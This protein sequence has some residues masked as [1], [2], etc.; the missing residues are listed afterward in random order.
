[1]LD[2]VS[3]MNQLQALFLH[4][5]ELGK[6]SHAYLFLGSDQ[7]A[8]QT[9]VALIAGKILREDPQNDVF[10]N[11]NLVKIDLLPEK[12]TLSVEQ[13]RSLRDIFAERSDDPQI[14]VIM[15]ADQMTDSAANSILK[16]IEEPYDNQFIFLLGT[17]FS[18][19][20]PTIL[21]RVQL[22]KIP[23]ASDHEISQQLINQGIQADE[24]IFVSKISRSIK[25]AKDLLTDGFAINLKR[26]I[27]QWL[28]AILLNDEKAF[29]FVQTDLLPFV[30]NADH[31]AIFAL[32]LSAELEMRLE[33]SCDLTRAMVFDTWLA[34]AQRSKFNVSWQLILE[35]FTL[36]A[37]RIMDGTKELSNK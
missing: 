6:L 17:H 11:G 34:I 13:M 26:A 12:K 29:A 36:E 27:D 14:A 4:S 3:K 35:S 24:A 10:Q 32:A 9:L 19:I 1:M 23:Q 7:R 33:M 28:D 15:H 21:S 25:Q 2:Q 16:F 31:Q 18:Q 8:A 20:L 22:I 37:L 5:I 30:D